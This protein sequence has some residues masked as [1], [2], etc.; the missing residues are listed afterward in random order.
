MPVGVSVFPREI[1]QPPKIWAERV[2]SH[3]FYWNDHIARGGHFAAFEQ[4]GLFVTELRNCF[5]ALR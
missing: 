4:P 1:Y 3:L 5:R 2:Y